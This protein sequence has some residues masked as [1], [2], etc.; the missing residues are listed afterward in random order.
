MAVTHYLEWI[1]IIERNHI[2]LLCTIH[3]TL[4]DIYMDY[5]WTQL[6]NPIWHFLVLYSKYLKDGHQLE[7]QRLAQCQ[8][9]GQIFTF[10][11]RCSMLIYFQCHFSALFN[12]LKVAFCKK[13]TFWAIV[14][15]TIAKSLTNENCYKNSGHCFSPK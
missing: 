3:C 13:D 12:F 2:R 4:F 15:T 7:Q 14:T 8:Y 11:F 1:K 10:P 5:G 6:L 9:Y